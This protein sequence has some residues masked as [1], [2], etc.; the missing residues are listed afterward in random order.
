MKTRRSFLS[1]LAITALLGASVAMAQATK[2]Q[3]TQT[4]P[5]TATVGKPAPNF[6]LTDTS[7]KEHSL[8]DFKG[9]NVVLQWINPDC[10]VCRR[11]TKD[12]LVAGM[13]KDLHEIDEDVVYI[14]VNST[15]YMEAEQSA[16]YFKDH[17]LE[18]PILVDKDGKVGKLYGAK[19][20]PHCYV[21]DAKGVL[22][23]SGA[24]DDDARGSKGDER[25]NYVVNAM[26]QIM[27]GEE[28]TPATTRSY[29]CSVKYA[30]GAKSTGDGKGRGGR[31]ERGG[32]GGGKQG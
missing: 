18:A 5:K 7:G 6:T 9:K 25:T 31:G 20:T 8:S 13:L 17:K 27:A 4:G 3:V 15:H 21:I 26:K 16:K 11:V 19:T 29:G 1:A 30:K 23:Y 22:R 24:F 10:P 12:G 32:R 28:V 2:P 14:A